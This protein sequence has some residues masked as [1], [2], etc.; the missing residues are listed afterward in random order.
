MGKN[1]NWIAKIA[2]QV[3]N[4]VKRRNKDNKKIICSS[5]ISPS[6]IIHLGNFREMFSVHII[7]EE[8]V[9]RCL[10]VEHLH[11]WDDYD[12]LRKIPS[13]VPET[14]NQ[15][16]GMPLSAVPNPFGEGSW[17]DH[18]INRFQ[19]E[20]EILGIK[21][22]FIRQS[23]RYLANT[24]NE[25]AKNAIDSRFEIF[26]ILVQYMSEERQEEE[27]KKKDNYYPFK[28]YCESCNTDNTVIDAYE[29]ETATI[30]YHCDKC[31][32]VSS[33]SLNDK[34]SG[35]LV[36]K[37]DWPMRW[38]FYGVDYEPG[39]IDHSTEGSSFT[40]GKQIVKN[41]MA[42]IPPHY[43]GYAFVRLAGAST[44]ISSSTGSIATPENALKILEPAMFRWLY[45]RT[46]MRRE[47]TIN[48]DQQ[49]VR[50]YDEWDR[51]LKKVADGK[52]SDSEQFV[53]DKCLKTSIKDID[54]SN[55]SIPFKL[56]A[57]SIEMTDNNLKEIVRIVSEHS[58]NDYD[59]E[60]FLKEAGIRYQ[61]AINWIEEF[62]SEEEKL[63]LNT[64][65]DQEVFDSLDEQLQ[66]GIVQLAGELEENWDLKA[67]NKLVYRVPKDL[68][69][70]PADV[71]PTPELKELQRD[72]FVAIYRLV[73]Q[74]ET[75]PR[76]PTLFVSLG[77]ERMR[78]LF[79]PI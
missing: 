47:F 58:E 36:W 68:M 62:Q 74:D 41:V 67:L 71:K 4:F 65:F 59:E 55:G 66:K 30:S 18:F 50:L 43:V 6:G 40:V 56:L 17:A 33:Y 9:Q 63:K 15:Y 49:I 54:H 32:N 75:G 11:F 13:G 28:V 57:S 5:G 29:K 77:L 10:D 22:T 61:L 60:S 14:F 70:L 39:G 48:F 1:K 19:N 20:L 73:L 45:N 23:E 76:L 79:S 7:V 37:V 3:E 25:A 42:D 12:R 72:F 46:D 52:A 34:A 44:K 26:D 78:T 27:Q 69:G 21:P 31:E 53:L 8:L 51:L 64:E 38:K 2:D 35:K 16:I 24:Y